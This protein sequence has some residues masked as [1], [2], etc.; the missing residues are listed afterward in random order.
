MVTEAGGEGGLEG[1]DATVTKRRVPKPAVAAGSTV[2]KRLMNGVGD[3]IGVTPARGVVAA[4]AGD[5]HLVIDVFV[6]MLDGT[7]APAIVEAADGGG[8]PVD[9]DWTQSL[10]ATSSSTRR[11]G[12]EGVASRGGGQLLHGA[13]SSSFASG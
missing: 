4:A 7:V 1:L 12:L 3:A 10:T 9:V 5:V 13:T 2:V 8:M 6:L 11:G